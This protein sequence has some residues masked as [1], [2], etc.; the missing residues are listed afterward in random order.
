MTSVALPWDRFT[1]TPEQ[2]A[3]APVVPP[4]TPRPAPV[5]APAPQ[6]APRAPTVEDVS[7]QL[8][9][10]L[11]RLWPDIK[12][13]LA[14]YARDTWAGIRKGQTVDILHPTITATDVSGREL[15]V[16]DARSRSW[17]T[18]LQGLI[19]DLFAGLTAA[20]AVLA[21]AD[22]F[23]KETWIAFGVLVLKTFASAGL[24]YVMRLRATPTVRTK[25]PEVALMPLPRPVSK[26]NERNTP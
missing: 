19:F 26:N 11:E 3:P 10:E 7:A 15:V 24:S 12:D 13:L 1:P 8:S 18:L 23:V 5:P 4:P 17:R 22:P 6:P 9:E 14:G 16:A 20:I 2:P 25:G 21:G